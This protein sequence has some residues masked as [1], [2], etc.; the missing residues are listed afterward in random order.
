MLLVVW[1]CLLLHESNGWFQFGL[2]YS[3]DI[4]PIAALG[5]IAA[6]HSIKRNGAMLALTAF[7]VC[8]NLYGIRWVTSQ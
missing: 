6:F 7:S 2:R 5:A 3:I 1:S 8:I 4:A